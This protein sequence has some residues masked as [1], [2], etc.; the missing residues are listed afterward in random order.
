M[1]TV[2]TTQFIRPFSTLVWFAIV[3]LYSV[4]FLA[5]MSAY[6]QHLTHFSGFVLTNGFSGG[7]EST[8]AFQSALSASGFSAGF[9]IGWALLRD[10]L[11]L[12]FFLAIGLIIFWQRGREGIGWY[13]SLILVLF[14][15]VFGSLIGAPDYGE[16]NKWVDFLIGLPW[17]GFYIFFYIFPDG[18][19]VP[20][21]TRYTAILVGLLIIYVSL[22]SLTDQTPGPWIGLFIVL[23]FGVSLVAQV[24]RYRS[25]STPLQRQQTKWPLWSII[26]MITSIFMGVV[27][28]PA[29]FPAVRT[30]DP[31]RLVYDW[32]MG[33]MTSIATLLLPLGLGFAILRYRLWDIDLIIRKTLIYGV[34]SGLLALVYFGMVILLQSMFDSVSGQQSPIAIVITTLVIAALFAPLRRRVQA[35]IDRRFF[36]K[37]YDAQQVLAQFAV[38][39]RD[40]LSLEALTAEL[41]CVVQETMQPEHVNVW[42]KPS[43]RNKVEV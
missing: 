7:W 18:R 34:L 13:T 27:I 6:W 33:I 14:G 16:W 8:A 23:T 5:G 22:S 2:A 1:K 9:Y 21:W 29:L 24:Y 17:L 42:L 35:V 28:I 12:V 11:G 10:S 20:A 31:T 39:V 40:E 26:I 4:L 36:R 41:T 3:A 37:K 30:D 43:G 32:G 25:I 38:T 19:F 15:L